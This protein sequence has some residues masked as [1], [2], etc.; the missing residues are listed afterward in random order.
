MSK[1]MLLSSQRIFANQIIAGNASLN[2]ESELSA[3]LS[4]WMSQQKNS[5]ELISREGKVQPVWQLVETLD[6]RAPSELLKVLDN[7]RFD[8]DHE[9]FFAPLPLTVATYMI[10]EMVIRSSRGKRKIKELRQTKTA[11]DRLRYMITVVRDS[12]LWL[13]DLLAYRSDWAHL[14]VPDSDTESQRETLDRIQWLTW[15]APRDFCEGSPEKQS[16]CDQEMSYLDGL[17]RMFERNPWPPIQFAFC[18]AGLEATGSWSGS[19]AW[20]KYSR[21]IGPLL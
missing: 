14:L 12:F 2:S 7:V 4:A 13:D 11:D 5:E 9:E 6:L 1:D 3:F 19:D 8:L 21:L 16:L 20:L 18:L 10:E 17:W 15:E